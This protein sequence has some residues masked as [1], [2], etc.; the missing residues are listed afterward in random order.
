MLP[1]VN[2]LG[3]RTRRRRKLV[4]WLHEVIEETDLTLLQDFL[5]SPQNGLEQQSPIQKALGPI[6]DQAKKTYSQQVPKASNILLI[7]FADGE[8]FH[9]WLISLRTLLLGIGVPSHRANKSQAEKAF[10]VLGRKTQAVDTIAS[11][12]STK[13]L[14]SSLFTY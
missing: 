5:G 3:F 8:G 13:T 12:N 9:E 14:F 4:V 11:L 2:L 6:T 10:L 1:V 7:Y